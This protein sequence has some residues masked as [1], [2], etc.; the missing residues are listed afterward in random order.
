[1][2]ESALTVVACKSVDAINNG[3]QEEEE[4]EGERKRDR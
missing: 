2:C 1:M 4:E 3:G